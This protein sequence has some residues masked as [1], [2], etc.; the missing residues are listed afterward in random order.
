MFLLGQGY[1]YSQR[2]SLSLVF[3]LHSG[4]SPKGVRSAGLVSQHFGKGS[5]QSPQD[6]DGPKDDPHPEECNE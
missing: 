1:D 3:F 4:S 6:D 5:H 2:G